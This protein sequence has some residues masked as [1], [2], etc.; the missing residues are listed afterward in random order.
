MCIPE[1]ERTLLA[2]L[3]SAIIPRNSVSTAVIGLI[4]LSDYSVTYG[5]H[6]YVVI[7]HVG[8]NRIASDK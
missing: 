4:R 6:Q 3:A 7:V 8:T 1:T 5:A 2:Q